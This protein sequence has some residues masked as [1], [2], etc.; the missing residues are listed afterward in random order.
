MAAYAADG[1]VSASSV[2]EVVHLGELG[3][4]GRLRPLSGILPAVLAA[5][6]A[7]F[8]TVLVPTGNAAE[9]A[10]VPELRVVPVASLREA[11]IFHGART[12]A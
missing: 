5:V 12:R 8:R 4:D 3:L 7:G 11:A 9:A 2:S 6:R 1:K 10:L